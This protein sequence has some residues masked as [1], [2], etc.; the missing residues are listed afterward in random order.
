VLQC[1]ILQTISQYIN[2]KIF[3]FLTYSIIH[4]LKLKVG[5]LHEAW[6]VKE[7]MYRERVV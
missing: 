5:Y 2:N 4:H 3:P 1:I 7:Q 6:N